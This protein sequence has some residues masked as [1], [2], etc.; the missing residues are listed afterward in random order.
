MLEIEVQG[1]PPTIYKAHRV[2]K[3]GRG[4]YRSA[5]Y[6]NWI[7]LVRIAQHRGLCDLDHEAFSVVVDFYGS[8]RTKKGFLKKKD[9][10]NLQKACI[11][12]ICNKLGI[13]DSRF[14]TVTA[15]KIESAK[16]ITI[17]RIFPCELSVDKAD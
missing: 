4:R 1:W 2:R 16:T 9:V 12:A 5:E 11:D 6:E 14:V 3:F 10:E 17:V 13:D 15:R 8:W 7:K